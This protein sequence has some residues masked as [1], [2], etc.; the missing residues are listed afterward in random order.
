MKPLDT[1][2]AIGRIQLKQLNEFI[3]DRKK[4]WNIL[5]IGLDELQE[6]FEFTLPTHATGWSP[7]GF[8][9]DD[10]GNR[11]E[12]SWFGFMLRVRENAP[13]KASHLARHLDE[14]KISNRMLFGGNLLLQ[15]AFQQLKKDRPGAFRIV[16]NLKGANKLM[17]QSLFLGTY[18]G[19]SNN[20]IE[21][22][23]EV[24]RKYVKSL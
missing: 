5:R 21:Y 23:M 7:K 11:S 13:F 17:R 19:L 22:E 6:F 1:Q 3:K 20:M 18:P 14:H 8:Q 15:P 12:C 16:G 2:A 4:N 24:I 9:W 10:S